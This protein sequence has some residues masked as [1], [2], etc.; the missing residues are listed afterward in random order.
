MTRRIA[1]LAL[2][3]AASACASPAPPDE[4]P[5]PAPVAESPEPDSVTRERMRRPMS[6]VRSTYDAAVAPGICWVQLAGD[7]LVQRNQAYV[8]PV[9]PG[10]Q[11][12]LVVVTV[13]L[14]V[15]RLTSGGTVLIADAVGAAVISA[16]TAACL[17]DM[18]P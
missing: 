2:C 8:K 6:A 7:A 16:Q 1:A 3:L 15:A 10:N 18:P 14:P 17:A 13:R 4:S 9:G 11:L 5:V 12:P